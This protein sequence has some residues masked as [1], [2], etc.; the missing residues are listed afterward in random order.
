VMMLLPSAISKLKGDTPAPLR[1]ARVNR[2]LAVVCVAL[3]VL[4]TVVTL[5]RPVSWFTSAYPTRAIPGLKPLIAADPKVRIF[6]DVHYAD[7]LIWEDPQLF[8]GRVAYDTS[9]ELLT[10][11][12]LQSIAT[13]SNPGGGIPVVLRPYGLWV[14]NP[15]NKAGNR[16]LLAQP[17]VHVVLRNKRVLIVTHAITGSGSVA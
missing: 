2:L 4:T 13:V 7:W 8:G 1:R 15:S 12:Q 11:S 9:L 6:A 16:H 3:A 5:A 17:G 10:D 14:L